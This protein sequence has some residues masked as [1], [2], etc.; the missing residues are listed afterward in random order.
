MIGRLQALLLAAAGLD[1]KTSEDAVSSAGRFRRGTKQRRGGGNGGRPAGHSGTRSRATRPA[2][3]G[4]HE[5]HLDLPADLP[6]TL[7]ARSPQ[8]GGL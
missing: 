2:A 6:L 8:A 7:D 5:T 1:L 4:R 3:S